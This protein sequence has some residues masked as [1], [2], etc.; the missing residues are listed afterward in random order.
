MPEKPSA[1]TR[2]VRAGV[3]SSIL[4]GIRAPETPKRIVPPQGTGTIYHLGLHF[5]AAGVPWQEPHAPQDT[6]RRR[7]PREVIGAPATRRRHHA[8]HLATS[9]ARKRD[10]GD[11]RASAHRHYRHQRPASP[12]GFAV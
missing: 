3:I 7:Q 5:G 6:T 2:S 11:P 4:S 1:R 8:T 12:C 9:D 10:G